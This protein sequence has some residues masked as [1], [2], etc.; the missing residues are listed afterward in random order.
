MFEQRGAQL[1]VANVLLAA[2][3]LVAAS[4]RAHPETA[5]PGFSGTGVD[6]SQ[7]GE[8]TAEQVY[9]NIQVL[10]DLRAA[11]LD[12]VMN[13]MCAALGVG[14]AYCHTNPWDSD[15]KSAKLAARRMILMTRSI[16]NEH[17]SRNPAV[18]CNT[19][20]RGQHN[21]VPNPPADLAVVHSP[22]D[23]LTAPK[24]PSLP[25][26]DEL[27]SRY[28]R[29]IGGEPAIQKIKTRVS[30]GT[31]TTTNRM[32]QP[33]TTPIEIYQTAADKLL[34]VRNNPRGATE[35]AFDGVK[36]WTKDSRGHREM[37]G[38]ELAEA[39]RD[40]DLFRYLKIKATYPQM[41]VLAKERLGIREAYVVGA[42]SRDDS[43]E[44]LY[45]DARTGLLSRRYVA[46]KTAFGTIPE[47]TGF[48]DYRL[49]NGVKLPFSITWSRP[50]F[51]ST[52]KFAE[53]R[54]NAIID[55]SR[56]E[57]RAR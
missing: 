4:G 36:G 2:L 32:T 31:E 56:F 23:E 38:S 51:S 22:D 13:F 26:I 21:S 25:S 15:E 37:E 53:I 3:F 42:T 10:K 6:Q 50:P 54:L 5:A 35:E 47:V 34:I 45:F 14:C 30:F 40:A 33:Q 9:K 57:P 41:R 55:D 20:H 44:K 49:V 7:S 39:K 46:F 27:V 43:R 48:D 16:N 29:A 52:R 19:C 11:E 18:T 8:K 28:I 1:V 24:P 17:F 12:G